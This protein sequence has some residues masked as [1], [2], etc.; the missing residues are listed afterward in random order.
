MTVSVLKKIGSL[1]FAALIIPQFVFSAELDVKI[2]NDFFGGYTLSVS[3]KNSK[4][5]EPGGDPEC[6]GAEAEYAGVSRNFSWING[7]SSSSLSLQYRII[8]AKEGAVVI[9]PFDVIVDGETYRTKEVRFNAKKHISRRSIFDEEDEEQ[10]SEAEIIPRVE[11]ADKK[12]YAGDAVCV[13][14]IILSDGESDIRIEAL[15]ESPKTDGFYSK[16]FVLP[17]ALTEV[18]FKGKKYRAWTAINYVFVPLKPGEYEIGGGSVIY[19]LESGRFFNS[20]QNRELRFPVKKIKVSSLPQGAPEDF[21]AAVGNFSLTGET[22]KTEAKVHSE[23]PLTLQLKGSGNIFTIKDPVAEK[24]D[25]YQIVIKGEEP[26]IDLK[27]AVFSGVKKY[28]VSIIPLKKGRLENVKIHM[29]VFDPALSKYVNL[30]YI[31]PDYDIADSAADASIAEK[32]ETDNESD[33]RIVIFALLAVLI[34]VLALVIVLRNRK[35]VR[36]VPLKNKTGNESDVSIFQDKPSLLNERLQLIISGAVDTQESL[37]ILYNVLND[38]SSS[39]AEIKAEKEYLDG[40]R[41]GG[42]KP[43]SEML[44][45]ISMKFIKLL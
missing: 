35:I 12:Y 18:S 14:Y 21:A 1:F 40:V 34:A 28:N 44:K 6:V 29:S 38:L 3:A 32:Q 9:K 41:F 5:I 4:Q 24:N 2:E 8:P 10:V 30:E 11:V 33:P 19:S 22:G 43:D 13:R 23:I 42:V 36:S 39:T 26:Q 20:F 37:K 15:G 7:K 17:D 31:L 27:G 45:N 16:R 25:N